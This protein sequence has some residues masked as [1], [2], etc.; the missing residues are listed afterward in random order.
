VSFEALEVPSDICEAVV[1][2]VAQV[3]DQGGPHVDS[4]R[5]REVG[6]EGRFVVGDPADGA[7][8]FESVE[9]SGPGKDAVL[10]TPSTG[11]GDADKVMSLEEEGFVVGVPVFTG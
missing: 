4:A 6:D 10:N 5:W 8:C 2:D 9:G 3:L 11:A 7:F 1:R